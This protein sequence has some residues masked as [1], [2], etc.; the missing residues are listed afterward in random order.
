MIHQ[1]SN[2]NQVPLKGTSASSPKKIYSDYS[3]AYP[4][5]LQK[6]RTRGGVK[7]PFPLKLFQM[8]ESIDLYSPEFSQFISWQPHGRCFRVHNLEQFREQVL[9]KFFNHTQYTSFRR[10][11]NL[12]GFTRL[13][14]KGDP[15]IGAYYHEMFLRGKPF[16]C[17]GIIRT[18]IVGGGNKKSSQDASKKS[19]KAEPKFYSMPPMPPPSKIST[20]SEPEFSSMPP[21]PPRDT[22]T[23]MPEVESDNG[24]GEV[25]M[26]YIEQACGS[27]VSRLEETR[28]L[29]NQ[30]F[31]EA[32]ES[33]QD[34]LSLLPLPTMNLTT[35]VR[36]PTVHPMQHEHAGFNPTS[37]C[38]DIPE[39][40]CSTKNYQD[41]C[42]DVNSAWERY[43][44]QHASS[45]SVYDNLTPFVGVPPPLTQ[46]EWD[47]IK[48]LVSRIK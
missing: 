44:T 39:D 4:D 3:K 14:E 2:V 13:V 40:W 10:Q 21:M 17:H 8:L 29:S 36:L 15:D 18:P 33:L 48:D 37:S 30:N 9:P 19:P 43:N 47:Q 20:N 46:N 45:S 11:L 25:E 26:D 35:S 28:T 12:W 32:F 5:S 42:H 24:A 34:P 16:L 23:N 7:V 6:V 38:C 31:E 41:P 27:D 1:S 22:I